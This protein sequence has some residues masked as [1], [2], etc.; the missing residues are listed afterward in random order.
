MAS[1]PY[2]VAL[3]IGVLC[4]PQRWNRGIRVPDCS[5]RRDPLG[6]LAAQTSRYSSNHDPQQKQR[7]QAHRRTETSLSD[8]SGPATEGSVDSLPR[9]FGKG[10]PGSI[11]RRQPVNHGP[12]AVAHPEHGQQ[13]AQIKSNQNQ[14]NS[15]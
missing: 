11:Q 3:M 13:D 1:A 14:V 9:R 4:L 6:L 15:A 10:L 5:Q 12:L 8:L 2:V 7:E